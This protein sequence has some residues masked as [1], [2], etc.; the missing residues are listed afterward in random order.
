MTHP[1]HE[2]EARELIDGADAPRS[3]ELSQVASPEIVVSAAAR[4]RLAAG[5][6][7]LL[8]AIGATY[9]V[10]GLQVFQP[11]KAGEDYLPFWNV[12]GR[13][14]LGQEQEIL[15]QA[16]RIAELQQMA[17]APPSESARANAGGVSPAEDAGAEATSS[18]EADATP[19]AVPVYPEY[20]ALEE[21][22]QPPAV[23]IEGPE[24][25]DYFYESLTLTELRYSNAIT[26]AGHWGDSVLGNDGVTSAIRRR[27]Q[28]RFGDSGHGFHVLG[29]YN[30]AYLHQGVRFED[31][32]G[33]RRCLIIFKC[34][35]DGHYGYGGVS[36][37]SAG[38]G[39]SFWATA[40]EGFGSRVSRFELWYARLPDGGKLQIKVDGRVERVVDTAAEHLGDGFV[41]IQVPDGPHEFEVRAIGGGLVRGYGAV[42]ERDV[43]GVTWDG[44]ALIGSFTQRLDYQ[45]PVHIARQIARR[46]ND[47]LVFML[48]G[49]DV[50]R[51]RMDLVRTMQ[52]YEEEYRRVIRKFRAGKSKA[53]CLIMSLL[54]HGERVGAHEIRTRRIVP[55]MVESQRKVALQEGCAFFDTFTAMGGEGSIGRWYRSKPALA[56]PDLA[57]AT[58]VGHEVIA[59][60]LVRA[61]MYGYAQFRERQQGEPLPLDDHLSGWAGKEAPIGG[62]TEA[63]DRGLPGDAGATLDAAKR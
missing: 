49:N 61:L 33:W 31:R 38:G 27:L 22:Q 21:E 5:L 40:R 54:D 32:G 47:L 6:L 23:V 55:R 62:A 18:R 39:T 24:A 30:M 7:T 16:R 59:G 13:E 35:P 19:V 34:E 29:R 36:S 25:L 41:T 46:D 63:R 8:V 9:L 20:R 14:W 52:P 44:L 57:H 1:P 58:S 4:R 56:G 60:L 43:P 2:E 37:A 48:G 15:E 12:V 45:D 53:S 3:V 42:L 17:Q 26:R 28:A 11:W 51:E 50:Q 10:P